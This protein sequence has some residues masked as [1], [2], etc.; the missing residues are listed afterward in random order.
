VKVDKRFLLSV[1]FIIVLSWADVLFVGT[2]T[3]NALSGSVRQI[4]HLGFLFVIFIIGLL[5]WKNKKPIWMTSLWQILY[6][7]ALGDFLLIA[8]LSIM[9]D[10]E[11]VTNS[12]EAGIFFRNTFIGPLPFLVSWV[13]GKV[14]I[15]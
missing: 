11:W 13:L 9:K 8:L 1:A 3:V 7:V 6:T 10:S 12:R 5:Y 4:L 2:H 15:K 14:Y